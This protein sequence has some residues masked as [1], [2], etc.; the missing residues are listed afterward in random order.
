MFILSGFTGVFICTAYD[1]FPDLTVL[2]FRLKIVLL[3]IGID[4]RHYPSLLCSRGL[5]PTLP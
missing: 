1:D 2:L 5:W 3:L 4:S